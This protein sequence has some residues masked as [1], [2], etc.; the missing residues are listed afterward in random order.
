MT[1]Y[2]LLIGINYKGTPQALRGCIND[3]LNMRK[4]L[5]E[6]RGY[7][8]ENIRVLSEE[9]GA[10]PTG[11]NIKHELS[12]LILNS[13]SKEADEIWLHYAGHGSSTRDLDGDED[14]GKDE[15]I[16][17]LDFRQNGMITDDELHDYLEHLPKKCRMYCIFDCCHSGTILDLKYQYKGNSRNGI[18]NPKAPIKGD[19][20]MISG[21][22]DRQTS[23]D[24]KINNKWCGAMTNSYI[25]CI[26]NGITCEQLL[27][28]MRECLKKGGYSQYPQ[29]CCSSSITNKQLW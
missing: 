27:N 10:K 1:K 26:K 2:A 5:I 16:V 24:A 7:K 29:M 11:P 23:A 15:T 17:P 4:Y 12:K 8:E 28:D 18:E 22:M 14:D 9:E 21:C 3:V 25:K 13:H 19:V 20:I 6:Q